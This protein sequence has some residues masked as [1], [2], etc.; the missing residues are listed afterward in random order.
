MKYLRFFKFF[1]KIVITLVVVPDQDD[2]HISF[3]NILF[4]SL[5]PLSLL[6]W[7]MKEIQ[8]V[9]FETRPISVLLNLLSV[10]DLFLLFFPRTLAVSSVSFLFCFL[11]RTKAPATYQSSSTAGRHSQWLSA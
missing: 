2:S 6:C 4:S 5:I 8:Y 3:H 11:K 7:D 1:F 10:L 9:A